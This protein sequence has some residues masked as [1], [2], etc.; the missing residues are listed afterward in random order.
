MPT[1]NQ[2]PL[3]S[4]L[5]AGD[6]LI[7]YS[8]NNGD[9]RRAPLSALLEWFENVFADPDYTTQITAPTSSGFNVALGQQTNNLFLII[10]PTGAFAAGSITLPAVATCFDGQEI[11]VVSSQSVAAL[12]L[13]GNGAT[14]IG[15]PTSIG[16]G[17]N[18]ALRFN[19]LQDTWYTI[20]QNQVSTFGTITVSGQINDGNSNPLIKISA[21]AAAVNEVTIANAATAGKP[22]ISATGTDANI[23]LNLVAKGTGAVQAGGVDVAT[24]TGAQTLTNKTLTSPT[25]TTPALGTPASGTLTNCTGLPISTGVAGLAANVAT[26]LATPSSA[27]LAAAITDETGSGAAVFATSPTLITPVLGAA[28]ATSLTSGAL[29]GAVQALSGTG[30]LGAVTLTNITTTVT[31]TGAATGTLADG[32]QG[33]IKIITMIVDGGDFVLTPVNLGGYTTITFNDAADSV[34]LVFAGTDWWVVSNVGTTLA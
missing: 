23:S 31:T 24:T 7:L 6:N 18:F 33:Q 14:I 3:A 4:T 26:F 20:S 10:N 27:N 1:I 19:E 25:L 12:T 2:L 21:T 22:Q 17:G 16:V 5:T 28:T 13:N 32:A 8:P 30:A 15:T 9:T 11:L 34:I 29:Q